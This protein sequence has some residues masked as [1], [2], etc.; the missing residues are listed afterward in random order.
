MAHHPDKATLVISS[1]NYSSWSLR[2]WLLLRL[3]GLQCEVRSVEAGDA[4][5]RAELLLQ[6]TLS[7]GE[8]PISGYTIE[9]FY[10]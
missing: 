2:G 4:R 9:I 3:S 10:P 8:R 7:A 1:R 5:A 6:T